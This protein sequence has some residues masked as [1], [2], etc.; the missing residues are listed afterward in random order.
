MSMR[1]PSISPVDSCNF[2]EPRGIL[3]FYIVEPPFS[4]SR[5]L[6]PGWRL[7]EVPRPTPI[8]GLSYLSHISHDG[9]VFPSNSMDRGR[10]TGSSSGSVQITNL[11][12]PPV[13]PQNLLEGGSTANGSAAGYLVTVA[14]RAQDGS[15]SSDARKS[16]TYSLSSAES[17]SSEESETDNDESSNKKNAHDGVRGM[18]ARGGTSNNAG[19]ENMGSQHSSSSSDQHRSPREEVPGVLAYPPLANSQRNLSDSFV[20]V[21]P[22]PLD[23]AY[24]PPNPLYRTF[25]R[26]Y[27]TST[28]P[29]D[30][31]FNAGLD[32][33]AAGLYLHRIEKTEDG[34]WGTVHDTRDWYKRIYPFRSIDGG[35]LQSMQDPPKKQRVS[36][37][38]HQEWN[39]REFEYVELAERAHPDFKEERLEGPLRSFHPQQSF[40]DSHAADIIL[41]ISATLTALDYTKHFSETARREQIST[42][43]LPFIADEYFDV[44]T[45]ENPRQ[46]F[47]KPPAYASIMAV[48]SFSAQAH[49]R[50]QLQLLADKLDQRPL[51]F[52]RVEYSRQTKYPTYDIDPE[53]PMQG[54]FAE[55]AKSYYLE[56]H[57]TLIWNVCQEQSHE[58]EF[59]QHQGRI[60]ALAIVLLRT[61]QLL[62]ILHRVL[63]R[64]GIRDTV[65]R[66]MMPPGWYI[67]LHLYSNP[68]LNEGDVNFLLATIHVL[69]KYHLFQVTDLLEG[70]IFHTMPDPGCIR[71]LLMLGFLNWESPAKLSNFDDKERLQDLLRLQK[72][73]HR[74][75]HEDRVYEARQYLE[76]N[77]DILEMVMNSETY[78]SRRPTA[79]D[80]Q[81]FTSKF[82]NEQ[83]RQSMAIKKPM[84][85]PPSSIVNSVIDVDAITD[86]FRT[87]GVAEPL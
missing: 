3:F 6:L 13:P 25:D 30:T 23:R 20:G 67:H 2:R 85:P 22:L 12:L 53:Y 54:V 29:S 69:K 50:R 14:A 86:L 15:P 55:L 52:D 18:A 83:A 47:Q 48:V 66:T 31:P 51:T 42:F 1:P 58:S 27:H 82:Y 26:T 40:D 46:L 9:R 77:G 71:I 37:R 75:S 32:E 21:K 73:I 34:E 38:F 74:M 8:S 84:P 87:P 45:P 39:Y 10:R 68:L 35:I 33:L 5:Q 59:M 79:T 44:P 36:V 64:M 24:S 62:H 49:R 76:D 65:E 80:P 70:L 43:P 41:L 56:P 81:S 57:Q 72:Q 4:P 61:R 17:S 28:L 7:T 78:F 63:A 16:Q 11:P 19:D 60:D